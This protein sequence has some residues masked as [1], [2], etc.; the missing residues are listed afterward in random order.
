MS[1]AS[2]KWLRA[3]KCF[4]ELRVVCIQREGSSEARSE[5]CETTASRGELGQTD[6]WKVTVDTGVRQGS[7]GQRPWQGVAEQPEPR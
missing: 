5:L 2:T 6:G 3:D 4:L 7:R 1:S